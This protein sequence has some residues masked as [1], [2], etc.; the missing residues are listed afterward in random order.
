ML[1]R[2]ISTLVA[3]SLAMLVWLYAR[4]RDQELLA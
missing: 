2:I 3:L 1:D 4:S